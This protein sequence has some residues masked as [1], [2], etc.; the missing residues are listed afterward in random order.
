MCSKAAFAMNLGL[1]IWSFFTGTGVGDSPLAYLAAFFPINLYV[2]GV[3]SGACENNSK[4]FNG[5]KSFWC[6]TVVPFDCIPIPIPDPL[7]Q[8]ASWAI[9]DTSDVLKILTT[10]ACNPSSSIPAI[11]S[12][13][14]AWFT[15]L[16]SSQTS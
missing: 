11:I 9:K 14:T 7:K 13:K 8:A 4:L 15:E 6:I 12:S 1:T 16:I 5:N 3:K 10:L 2:S